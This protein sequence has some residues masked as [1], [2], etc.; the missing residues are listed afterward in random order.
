VSSVAGS[1]ADRSVAASTVASP[2]PPSRAELLAALGARV[3]GP[4]DSAT[5][6]VVRA[7][8]RVNLIGEYTDINDGFV[9]P[10]AID[11]EIRIAFVPAEDGRVELTSL[12]SGETAAF[13]L[14]AIGEPRGTWVDYP[15][16]VA[17]IL[18]AEGIE[19]RGVRG[20]IASTL[21]PSS[22]L[23]SSA[24]LELATAWALA[25][26]P[27]AIDPLRLARLCQRAENEYV[28]V[29]CGLM[30]QFASAM[31][32]R[33][34]AVLLDCR[35]LDWRPVA[36][37]LDRATVVVAHTGSTRSLNASEYNARRA[38]CEHAV[39][40][41]ARRRPD[42]RALRDVDVAMLGEAAD[43]LDDT[44]V[45]RCEHVIGENARVLD[46]IDALAAGD[47]STVGRLLVES[48]VS[49][50]DLFEVSSPEL[51]ALVEIATA[52][53]GVYGARMTGAGFG[54]CIVALARPEAV[55]RL[56]TAIRRD[57]PGRTGLEPRIWAVTP[58]A[59]AGPVA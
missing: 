41:I 25:G 12:D 27:G 28:G 18:A 58:A 3:R 24:A 34:A 29:Q 49:L 38:Q 48:H 43:R 53:P 42:V 45:R 8:G 57:Y 54:G 51:D 9:M 6:T 7:P 20:V 56:A 13:D 37:P 16:G 11:L 35:S 17:T 26:D 19:L 22:G 55:E 21:P 46:A 47:L 32:R 2:R 14:D 30:D 31:G 40:V 52:V 44:T 4:F 36:L 15:A 23:S 59:G 39:D 33:G 1:A 10:A 5:A 50:R